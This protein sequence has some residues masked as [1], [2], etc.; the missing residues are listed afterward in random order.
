MP[1]ERLASGSEPE[2][3]FL[4]HG[5]PQVA[6]RKI[7]ARRR[8]ILRFAAHELGMVE[9]IGCLAYFSQP[10]FPALRHAVA[11][12]L[13][14]IDV[15]PVGKIAHSIGKAQVIRFHDEPEGIA[16]LAASETMPK[17]RARID[18]A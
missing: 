7:R 13:L 5:T 2:M 4:R 1:H 11:A 6:P 8:S 15:R 10:G 3:P 9:I 16:A 14:N 17:L 18:L 12:R